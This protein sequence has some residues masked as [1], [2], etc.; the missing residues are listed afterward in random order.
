MTEMNY[1]FSNINDNSLVI[2]DELGRGTSV[3]EGAAISWA[4]AEELLKTK[5]FF[6][7]ATHFLYLSK[8]EAM[9]SNALKYVD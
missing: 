9:Y 2:I 5:S 4:F 8:L 1:I 3:E 6:L 7:F